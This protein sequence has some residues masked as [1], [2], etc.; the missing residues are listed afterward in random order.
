LHADFS[1][2]L[3]VFSFAFA[4]SRLMN[5]NTSRFCPSP[6]PMG[7]GIKGEVFDG[8]C[9]PRTISQAQLQIE[10]EPHTAIEAVTAPW[11]TPATRRTQRRGSSEARR[12]SGGV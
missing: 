8:V 6:H 2:L 1:F 5:E 9:A 12:R 7:R 10:L 11:E 3:S 4:S